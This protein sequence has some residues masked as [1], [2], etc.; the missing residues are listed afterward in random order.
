MKLL[1]NKL[2]KAK[3]FIQVDDSIRRKFMKNK[4]FQ[5]WAIYEEM[6]SNK[7]GFVTT[8]KVLMDKIGFS[9]DMWDKYV[10]QLEE[11]GHI[12]RNKRSGSN[13]WTFIFHEKAVEASEAT[14]ETKSKFRADNRKK[15]AATVE[16]NRT[17]IPVQG[18][19]STF[20]KE[21]WE[22]YHTANNVY[23]LDMEST[24][25]YYIGVRSCDCSPYDDP[26]MGSMVTWV[27]DKKL[28]K[29]SIINLYMTREEANIAEIELITE[30]KKVKEDILCMNAH[31]PSVGF[32]MSG[33]KWSDER[34][35]VNK[36]R[37]EPDV[38]TYE[39]NLGFF[40]F[41]LDTMDW[42]NG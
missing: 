42:T 31:I 35:R 27:V 40:S 15:K 4:H 33:T 41:P 36:I 12:E 30:S 3:G 13:D 38:V 29:K 1:I 25:E 16:A 39:T 14:K 23:R 7:D 5:A 6:L 32:C 21:E 26:Y 2:K 37:R 24:G 18:D 8:T 10:R 17:G 20:T 22:E 19:D 34:K 11:M 28:L 9:K